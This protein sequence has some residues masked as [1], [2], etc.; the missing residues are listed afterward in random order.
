MANTIKLKRSSTASDTPTASDLEVGELAVNTA[1]AKLFTKHTDNSIKEI[2][3]SGGGGGAATNLTGLS[4]VT[5]SSVQNNDLLKYNSTA[6]E[7]QNTNLGV[8]VEPSISIDSG[9]YIG[10]R[11]AILTPSSGTYDQPAY[12]AE[13]RNA[14]NTATLVTNENIT[15]SGNTLSWEQFTAGTNLIL[16]V[17]TQDFGDLESEFGTQTFTASLFPA[18]RYYRLTGTG[19]STYTMVRDISL[20]TGLGQTGS[21]YPAVMTSDTTPT[22]YV[23]SSSGHYNSTFYEAWKAF[24]TSLFSGWWNLGLSATYSNW[25]VQIDLG[26]SFAIQSASLNI[27]PSYQGGSSGQTY[28]LAG[29]TTG[30]F[31]GEQV[32]IGSFTGK[33]SS[34]NQIV[35]N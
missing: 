30:A 23:A 31:T 5:I 21:D 32:V 17:K 18:R 3:G 12:F 22:P 4:D 13:V 15:K 11:T 34:A 28:T 19:G 7:W 26:S 9:V 35:I 10:A 2:S 25:Y 33:V 14:A 8:S 27:N 20:F 6:G 24:D 29:S 1:D 16:R